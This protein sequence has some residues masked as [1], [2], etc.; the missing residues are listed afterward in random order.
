MDAA[1]DGERPQ[2][3]ADH[4]SECAAC[5]AVWRELVALD[6]LL[7][8]PTAIRLPA[9]FEAATMARIGDDDLPAWL[10]R[11]RTRAALA[12]ATIA[13]GCLL[14]LAG[15]IAVVQAA[16][17]PSELR[18]WLDV[19]GLV[20]DAVVATAGA[21]LASVAHSALAWPLYAALALA[22]ALIWFG[23]LVLPR[24]AVGELWHRPGLTTTRR[25]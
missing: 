15:L 24:Q 18:A 23:A 9:A 19:G 13:T 5:G 22:V 20:A 7:R 12:L 8:V 17:Q 1:L 4:L 21:A 14:V 16:R 11:R 25:R 6:R 3:L 10:G 2:E